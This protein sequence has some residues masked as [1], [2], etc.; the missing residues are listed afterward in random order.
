MHH[1]RKAIAGSLQA[2][3]NVVAN[4]HVETEPLG[5]VEAKQLHV[6]LATV[7]D[8]IKAAEG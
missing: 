3:Q 8:Q 4:P 5:A 7:S 6:G 1:H 2:M